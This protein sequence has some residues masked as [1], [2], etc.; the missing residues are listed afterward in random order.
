MTPR[1]LLFVSSTPCPEPLQATLAAQGWALEPARN[2]RTALTRQRQVQAKAGLLFLD[3]VTRDFAS[4]FEAFRAADDTCEWVF[5]L[6]P[7]ALQDQA[8][9]ELV[10]HHCFDHHTDPADPGF[11]TRALG[12]AYGRA[13]LRLRAA[14][15]REGNE[16]GL[17]GN[18][19][20]ARQLRRLARRLAM[21]DSPVLI[22]GESGSGKEAV[23]RALHQASARA[24]EPLAVLDCSAFNAD[25]G[26]LFDAPK[27]TLVLDHVH[28]LP[29]DGQARLLR[30]LTEQATLRMKLGPGAVPV[31]VV[32]LCERPL[33]EAVAQERFRQDLYF[34]LSVLTVDVPPLRERKADVVPIARHFLAQTARDAGTRLR[35]LSQA[36]VAAL[37][38]H[39]WPGNVRELQNRVQRA[40]LLSDQRLLGPVELG[41]QAP[42]A[43]DDP[44]DSLD[45][46]RVRAEREAIAT[47]LDR[48]GHNVSL[49]ARELGVSRMTLYRLMAKHSIAP[50]ATA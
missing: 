1:S 44:T 8:L 38:A 34:R 45:A 22:Q 6:P 13:Q 33:Q 2:L 28:D 27:G 20:P 9:A 39:D 41:L 4:D 11:L 17:V 32:A 43:P 25:R 40:V 16:Q 48:V 37:E 47:S 50:R 49:A 14:A 26:R 10:L 35:T 23:A 31:R 19:G 7:D 15:A 46:I 24:E 29:R 42:A 30:L 5:V 36:A 21:T 18:S 3:R 12:H